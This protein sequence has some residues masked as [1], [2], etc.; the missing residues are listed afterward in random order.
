MFAKILKVSQEKEIPL[1]E[2]FLGIYKFF[3][4]FFLLIS[5]FTVIG[6]AVGVYFHFNSKKVYSGEVIA[7]SPVISNQRLVDLLNTLENI[8]KSGDKTLLAQTL[9]ISTEQAST[10]KELNASVIR[11]FEYLYDRDENPR[12]ESNCISL[13]IKS[14]DHTLFPV[15]NEKVEK[16][17]SSNEYLQ[18]RVLL[19]KSSIA[20]TIE[21]FEEEITEIDSLQ[22]LKLERMK[23]S[24]INDFFEL[25]LS[26]SETQSLI[27]KRQYENSKEDLAFVKPFV[28][29]QK[30]RAIPY[31]DAII[32][33]PLAIFG[34]LFFLFGI[35]VGLVLHFN[36][37]LRSFQRE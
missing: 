3:V 26:N 35:I 36:K 8:R 15:L 34:F 19:R 23:S 16:Y 4:R 14:E 1:H 31:S 32:Y 22:K 5:V 37:L 6:F 11:D 10:I 18:E 9:D 28:F 7:Y 30:M 24:S 29:I 13:K 33:K 17:I 21:K 12:Y 25:S 2:I 20:N 27:L